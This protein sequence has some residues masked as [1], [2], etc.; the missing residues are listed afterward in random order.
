[1]VT[2]PDSAPEM[3]N[4]KEIIDIRNPIG[5]RQGIDERI[6]LRGVRPIARRPRR[7]GPYGNVLRG[8]GLLRAAARG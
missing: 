6:R 8:R 3:K 2:A 1:V 7:N 5:E 4:W